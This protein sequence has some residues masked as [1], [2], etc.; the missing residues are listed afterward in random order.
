MKDSLKNTFPLDG[1]KVY[2][3]Y[4]PEDP[5]PLTGI[6]RSL[7][8]TFPLYRK[9]PPLAKNRKWFPLAGRFLSVKIDCH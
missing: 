9:L 8:N 1:K 5:L 2:G 4:K 3:V 6:K 7:K